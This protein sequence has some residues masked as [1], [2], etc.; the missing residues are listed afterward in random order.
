[1]SDLSFGRRYRLD[2]LA[3]QLAELSDEALTAI[4]A[5]AAVYYAMG[6]RESDEPEQTEPNHIAAV[7]VRRCDDC[8]NPI[9]EG[10]CGCNETIEAAIDEAARA[11]LL[12]HELDFST[13]TTT[14]APEPAPYRP[15]VGDEVTIPIPTMHGTR[16]G[17]VVAWLED[18]RVRVDVRGGRFV[19]VAVGLVK[20]AG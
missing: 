6:H 20:R 8:L 7:F 13:C 1:M 17:T 16:R 18:G 9:V 10:V 5:Q 3:R 19:D 11:E 14:V 15:T 12:A 4:E 2:Y